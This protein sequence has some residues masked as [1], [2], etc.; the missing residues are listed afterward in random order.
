MTMPSLGLHTNLIRRLLA[1]AILSA[2]IG[3][4]AQDNNSDPDSDEELE[5]E[6]VL[7]TGTR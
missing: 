6:E 3:L 5:V 4:Q 1:L 2:P 7:V